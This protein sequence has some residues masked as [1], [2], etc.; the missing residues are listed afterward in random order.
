MNFVPDSVP[1][2]YKNM[3][4]II[5]STIK[6]RTVNLSKKDRGNQR[7]TARASRCAGSSSEGLFGGVFLV[8]MTLSYVKEG[9]PAS[10]RMKNK[11]VFSF[12]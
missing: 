11:S 9:L 7:L 5:A 4:N 10:A 1:T 8:N 12:Y 6:I 3:A 2:A